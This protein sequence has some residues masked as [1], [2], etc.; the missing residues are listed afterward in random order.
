M[1]KFKYYIIIFL[2]C[3]FSASFAQTEVGNVTHLMTMSQDIKNPVRIVIDKFDNIYVTD[4]LNKKII[5]YNSD[6]TIEA[7]HNCSFTPTAVAIN[8]NNQLFVGNRETGQIMKLNSDGSFSVFYEGTVFPNSMTYCSENNCLY[9]ADSKLKKVIILTTNGSFV[10]TFGYGELVFPTGIT[11]DKNNSR[12]L[13]AEHGAIDGYLPL[14]VLIYDLSGNLLNTF[15]SY[16]AGDGQSYRNQGLAIGK[17]GNIFI[18]EPIQGVINVFDKDGNFLTKFGQYG[19]NDGDFNI[20]IDLSFDSN[21]RLFVLSLNKGTIDLFNFENIL[22][23]SKITN[24]DF[25]VC[26][27]QPVSIPVHFTGTAPWSFSYTINDLDTFTVNNTNDNPYIINSS[28]EGIYNV[29]SLTDANDV[30]T[31]FTGTAKIKNEILPTST[32]NLSTIEIS[33]TQQA[34]IPISFTGSYPWSIKYTINDIDTIEIQTI[35]SSEYSLQSSIEGVYKIIELIDSKCTGTSLTGNT[36]VVKISNPTAVLS[37][38]NPSLCQ[39]DS[40]DLIIDFTGLAPWSFTYTIN[41]TDSVYI[42]NNYFNPFIAKTAQEGIYKIVSL[43]DSLLTGTY[44]SGEITISRIPLPLANIIS[45]DEV[46]CENSFAEIMFDFQGTPPWSLTYKIDSGIISNLTNIFSSTLTVNAYNAGKY[47]LLNITDAY[48]PNSILNDSV[49][50]QHF[51]LPTATINSNDTTICYGNSANISIDFTGT[52]PWS[53]TY[54]VDG[55]I[56]DT[57]ITTTDSVFTFSSSTAG[58]YELNSLSDLNCISNN[59]SG[60][61]FV[62]VKSLPT[63]HLVN[64][65]ASFCS[66]ASVTAQIELT[67]TP[68]W[69]ISYSKDMIPQADITNILTSPYLIDL[70]EPG[71]F[72]LISVNDFNCNATD[73]SGN[74]FLTQNANPTATF[75]SDSLFLCLG[76]TSQIQVDLTGEA[77]WSFTYTLNGENPIQISD[78]QSTPYLLSVIDTGFYGIISINDINCQATNSSSTQ[79]SYNNLTTAELVTSYAKLCQN[80][81][82]DLEINLTGTAPWEFIYTVDGTNPTTISSIN[83]NTYILNVAEAGVYEITSVNDANNTST[84]VSGLATVELKVLPTAQ[85]I[86]NQK[87]FCSGD[88]SSFEVILTGTPPWNFSYTLDG[89]NPV[90]ISNTE[91]YVNLIQ[92]NQS[93]IY[94]I[95]TLSDNNC[96]GTL[97]NGSAEKIQNQIVYATL[98]FDTLVVS[99]GNTIDMPINFTGDAP[100]SF[101]YSLDGIYQNTIFNTSSNPYLLNISSPGIYRVYNLSDS[102][103]DGTSS[104][105]TLLEVYDLPTATLNTPNISICSGGNASVFIDLTGNAPWSL[106]YTIDGINPATITNINTNNYE[107]IVY[108]AGLY[109]ISNITDKYF[110]SNL[111]NGTTL[112]ELNNLPSS[113]I[114]SANLTYCQG[115]SANIDIELTGAAPW[116]ITY[117][118]NDLNPVTVNNINN[119]IFQLSVNEAGNYAI[120]AVSDA[121]QNGECFSG[122]AIVAENILPTASVLT[123]NTSICEGQIAEISLNLTGSSPWSITYTTDGLNPTIINSISQPNFTIPVSEQGLYELV[124]VS[125]AFCNGTD[126]SGST[127]ITTIPLPIPSFEFN[128]NNSEVSFNNTSLNADTYFW[129]FG[130][131]NTSTEI[132]PVHIYNND[133]TYNV[134]LTS[135]S[136]TCGDST[137]SSSI[138]IIGV[139]AENIID[140][141]H[142]NVFPNP[143]KNIANV[144]LIG[145]NGNIEIELHNSFGQILKSQSLSKYGNFITVDLKDIPVGVYYIKVIN[146]NYL[147][148]IKIIINK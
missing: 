65:S 46:V 104:G 47:K 142:V 148:T 141:R 82:V 62:T 91:N 131:G 76:S 108:S 111:I 99:T 64:D 35:N 74:V 17:C 26:E 101:S 79:V 92:V 94:E 140:S 50:I 144:E 22:P 81:T 138:I 116:S 15:G 105:Q 6:G 84:C 115:E 42:S 38:L 68:P 129:S 44:L 139:F 54:K 78:I 90:L 36:N 1:G 51:T 121:T 55:V 102:T 24:S 5:K 98:D 145:F 133:G 107:L 118:L 135:T 60:T 143:T 16:G 14:K 123:G 97:F 33:G 49:S 41:D 7:S 45:N 124:A 147:S 89:Q 80:S 8:D 48:C 122:S 27:S 146:E 39:G 112:V 56:I 3:C 57:T 67:G 23:T 30:G 9:I 83:Q 52:S 86:S 93:G 130:D 25:T 70:S 113:N 11:Y 40:S 119:N 126:L 19:I 77:P 59:L 21:D 109:E 110:D 2:I 66:G 73:I 127:Y 10:N 34:N 125:D 28:V 106:T 95:S 58:L 75:I 53:F 43:S 72:E 71:D 29:I 96:V 12:I 132:N 32:M 13:V 87:Y 137:Y 61:T 85:I 88:N 117:T 103:C 20:P 134:E 63:A 114:T 18:T 100:W 4:F 31:C 69:T 37:C 128:A 136:S 120:I